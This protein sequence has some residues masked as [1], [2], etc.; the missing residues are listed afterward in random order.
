MRV[1]VTMLM[2]VIMPVMIV[3]V[4]MVMAAAAAALVMVVLVR[5]DERRRQP[6]LDGDRLLARR[7]ARFDRERH[8]LRAEPHVVDL[9]EI[10]APEPPLAVEHEHGRR[11]R[12]S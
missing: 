12:I 3:V 6:P 7:V 10:V 9:A 1:V 8:H 2:V 11:A 4:I 5:I